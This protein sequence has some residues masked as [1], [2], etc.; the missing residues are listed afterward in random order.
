M[1]V[2]ILPWGDPKNWKYVEYCFENTCVKGFSTLAL[3]TSSPKIRPDLILI[4]VLDTL[5]D[6]VEHKNYKLL[7][8]EVRDKVK[9]YLCV[10]KELDIKIE[11]LPGIMKKRGELEITFRANP[12]DIRLKLLHHTYVSI[13][14]KINA[15]PK[16]NTL[17]ILIDTTH[18][19]NYFTILVREAVLEASTIL[20]VH[21]KN[22][23]VTAFNSDPF[24][25]KDLPKRSKS[26]PC[27]LEEGE[28]TLKTEYNLLYEVSIY[29]WDLTKYLRY[30]R[31]SA[32]KLLTDIRVCDFDQQRLRE[33]MNFSKKVVASYR[34]GALVEL[35]TLAREN[36]RA[37]HEILETVDEALK[38]WSMNAKIEKLSDNTY[39]T[40]FTK[41]QDG[42]RLLLHAHAILS[43]AKK[44]I[45]QQSFTTL[46]E[47]ERVRKELLRGSEI[48]STLVDSEIGII[49]KLAKIPEEWKLYAEV[50]EEESVRGKEDSKNL[51][52]IKRNFIA[53]AGFLKDSL[54]IRKRED[55]ELRIKK[56]YRDEIDKV[57]NKIFKELM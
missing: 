16:D 47:I 40:S 41:L 49:K 4:Y 32:G 7:T 28:A 39:R 14:S 55:I 24:T 25:S 12:N 13:L 10:S 15:K 6:N 2:A 17:E 48:T 11:V 19:V 45:N 36:P 9:N 18:G 29:P 5:S 38:C 46:T 35:L 57:L 31:D 3:L 26:D 21:G 20:A 54:E 23:K 30:S 8:S 1:R 27:R 44:L 37:S 22:V 56:E 34:V 43:S 51:E 50:L 53:H 52:R 42:L 33:L